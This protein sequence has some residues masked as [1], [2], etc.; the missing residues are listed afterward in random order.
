M[1]SM[2]IDHLFEENLCLDQGL[3]ESPGLGDVDLGVIRPVD[4]QQTVVSQGRGD[5]AGNK[6]LHFPPVFQY[7]WTQ[8]NCKTELS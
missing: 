1:A 7:F 8:Q 5:P 4:H 2:R 3:G 6:I